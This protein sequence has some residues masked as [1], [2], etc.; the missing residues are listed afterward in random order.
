MLQGKPASRSANPEYSSEYSGTIQ[1]REAREQTRLPAPDLSGIY[2]KQVDSFRFLSRE[3]EFL[4][5]S[6][7]QEIAKERQ[8]NL[9]GSLY[10]QR[11]T[12][13]ILKSS[14]E[15]KRSLQ[16]VFCVPYN[17]DLES[18]RCSLRECVDE[19][20]R[21]LLSSVRLSRCESSEGISDDKTSRLSRMVAKQKELFAGFQLYDRDLTLIEG[22][23]GELLKGMKSGSARPLGDAA[24][25]AGESA[26]RLEERLS[27]SKLLKSAYLA[28]K[29]KLV[30]TN[31]RFAALIVRR[32]RRDSNDTLDLIQEAN[33]ALMEAAERFQPET[34]LRFKTFAAKI[35]RGKILDAYT[36]TSRPIRLPGE[37]R[38]MLS[39]IAKFESQYLHDNGGSKPSTFEIAS[40][41]GIDESRVVNLLLLRENPLSFDFKKK[42]Q[43]RNEH[44]FEDKKSTTNGPLP[45]ALKSETVK[46]VREAVDTLSKSDREIISMLY[47]LPDDSGNYGKD[48]LLREVAEKINAPRQSTAV[49]AHAA[50]DKL[51]RK[52]P[53]C[54]TL[55]DLGNLN[56]P[57]Q[58]RD[59]R[60]KYSFYESPTM[61]PIS[62][63]DSVSVPA[64][65]I[66]EKHGIMVIGDLILA[67]YKK[68]C[69][70]PRISEKTAA[71][72]FNELQTILSEELGSKTVIQS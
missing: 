66:L 41:V 49:K 5:A 37:P 31:L 20:G 36:N 51:V 55:R 67:G 64:V 44:L 42:K 50:L 35:I 12:F 53:G 62:R 3:K 71:S 32:M 9:L 56:N 24:E 13:E 2:F 54:M 43:D 65:G 40:A 61:M 17:Y 1:A 38:N 25:Q 72:I 7:M 63:L 30:E 14:A 58:A 27:T 69:S 19:L 23:L 4:V 52:H 57:A 18:F 46:A 26:E 6:R 28:E 22:A 68:L 60:E 10:A 59:L 29:N 70:L 16:K 48:H 39:L 33:L 21:R 34:G 15:G 47:G 45:T 11:L 8:Q